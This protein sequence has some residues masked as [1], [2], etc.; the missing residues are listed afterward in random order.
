M[1]GAGL[2]RDRAATASL[3]AFALTI[4]ALL[5]VPTLFHHD[6]SVISV[7]AARGY[8][9][10]AAHL[11]I[12]ALVGACIAAAWWFA[13]PDALSPY[14]APSAR[15]TS[16][17]VTALQA[18]A[19]FAAVAFL[20][21]PPALARYGPFLEEQIHLAAVHRMLAGDAPFEDFEFLY[22]PLM[23]YPAYAWLK[24][25]GY[26]LENFYAYVLA[27]ELA[28]FAI[29]IY[30]V[31]ARLQNIWLR[32]GAF[33][34]IA[35]LCF[36]AMLGPNQNGLRKLFGVLILFSVAQAP[37]ARTRWVLH[38]LGV[39]ALLAYSQEFGAATAIGI[40][41]IY[42]A[43]FIKTRNTQAIIALAATGAASAVAWLSI[44]APLLGDNIGAYFESLA[45]LTQRF[46]AGEAAFP[47]YWTLSG[48]AQFALIFLAAWRVGVSLKAPWRGQAFASELMMIGAIAYALVA[49]KSGLSRADQWHIVPTILPIVFAFLLPLPA[50]AVAI[51]RRTRIAAAGLIVILAATYSIGQFAIAQYIF[52]DDGLLPGY[53][54]IARN[55]PAPAPLA[56][57]PAYPALLAGNYHDLPEIRALSAFISEPPYRG[58]RVLTYRRGWS[59]PAFVGALKAG[60]LADDYIYSDARGE[61]IVAYLDAHPDTLIFMPP[62]DYAWLR[63][64]PDTPPEGP[65][66]SAFYGSPLAQAGAI[67]SSVHAPAI[68]LEEEQKQ[69]RWRRLVGGYV[70]QHYRPVF[71]SGPVMVLARDDA[72]GTFSP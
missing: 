16:W 54:S 60:P 49:L 61:E 44:L 10:G 8:H 65:G 11:T 27:I 66:R 35:A 38:G 4:P 50:G 33:T 7:A 70:V 14:A 56:P 41:A 48:L 34:L 45:L 30:L 21:F 46:N 23:L 59:R 68:P 52:R 37:Y 36:N 6:P 40:A 53:K 18:A 69:L 63:A 57:E 13:R 67:L 71:E 39:G 47:F 1:T 31:Q 22:G 3:L 26:T 25:T 2:L 15:P 29:I 12:V 5:W 9:N 42:T 19:V 72:T 43:L 32:L 20:Y 17:R 28:A 64:D 51:G 62:A 58:R 24:T 55:D